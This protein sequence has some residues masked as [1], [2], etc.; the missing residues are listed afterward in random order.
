MIRVIGLR[1]TAFKFWDHLWNRFSC[2]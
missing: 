1:I 2:E